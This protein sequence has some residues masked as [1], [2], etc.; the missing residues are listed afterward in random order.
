[1]PFRLHTF[2]PFISRMSQNSFAFLIICFTPLA[3]YY[4]KS[5]YSPFL[6]WFVLVLFVL[7]GFLAGSRSSSVLVLAG[8]ILAL[9]IQK[10]SLK[11]IFTLGVFVVLPFTFLV[12]TP[13]VKQL[14]NSLNPRAYRLIYQ[15][16]D[17]IE[18][19]N[20]FLVRMVQ[21]EKG[22]KIFDKYPLTGIG[23]N[24]F[25]SHTDV[26]LTGVFEGT[27]YIT[28][29]KNIKEKSAHNSYISILAEGGLILAIPF[30]LLLLL[31][32]FRTLYYIKHLDSFSLIVIIGFIAMLIH[33]WFISAILNVFAWFIIGLATALLQNKADKAKFPKQI[34]KIGYAETVV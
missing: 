26:K 3:M 19:D 4:L 15:T 1:M 27:K 23:L 34:K 22:L 25:G 12:Q 29:K 33:L 18:Y 16:S 2:I 7:A 21:V 5:R 17:V 11:T 32:I 20:S 30:A 28:K 9:T 8:G 10:I 13:V 31:N 24:N 14:V 6:S